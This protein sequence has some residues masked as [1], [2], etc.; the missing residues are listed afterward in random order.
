M[1]VPNTLARLGFIAD[2]HIHAVEIENECSRP[3]SLRSQPL[4]NEHALLSRIGPVTRRL[5]LGR[6]VDLRVRRK[7]RGIET[8]KHTNK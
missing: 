8:I 5:A 6:H 3:R 7:S 2:A 4:A 1:T